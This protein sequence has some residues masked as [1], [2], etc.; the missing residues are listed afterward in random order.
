LKFAGKILA[1]LNLQA[2]LQ[3]LIQRESVPQI[4]DRGL[5]SGTL[6]GFEFVRLIAL[7]LDL[8]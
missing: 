6:D 5:I 2:V 7:L 8:F 1:A 4:Q 3:P